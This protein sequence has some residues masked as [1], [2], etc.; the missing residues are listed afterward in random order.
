MHLQ[1]QGSAQSDRRRPESTE[2]GGFAVRNIRV[3]PFISFAIRPVVPNKERRDDKDDK[4]KHAEENINAGTTVLGGRVSWESDAERHKNKG[5][6]APA[7]ETAFEAS[8]EPS[9]VT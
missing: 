5:S 6:F 3:R 1:H 7:T 9:A 8:S 4:A 2:S